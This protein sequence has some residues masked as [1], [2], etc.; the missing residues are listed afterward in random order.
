MP[1]KLP[2]FII[3]SGLPFYVVIDQ[4]KDPGF[5][6]LKKQEAARTL[7]KS[8]NAAY[9]SRAE[10]YATRDML[11]EDYYDEEGGVSKTRFKDS[12]IV[13]QADE[14]GRIFIDKDNVALARKTLREIRVTHPDVDLDDL[15]YMLSEETEEPK[16]VNKGGRPRKNPA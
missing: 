2:F 13:A 14:R 7:P 15:G 4:K 6:E 1:P 8:V 5:A 3:E 16:P 10:N 11:I 12:I 9:G